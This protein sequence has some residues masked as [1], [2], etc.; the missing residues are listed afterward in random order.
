M[1]WNSTTTVFHPSAGSKTTR[2]TGLKIIRKQV[3]VLRACI[4]V[5]TWAFRHTSVCWRWQQLHRGRRAPPIISSQ[6]KNA[7]RCTYSILREAKMPK[8]AV[9]KLCYK[10]KS[11]FYTN[12]ATRMTLLAVL[13]EPHVSCWSNHSTRGAQHR[14]LTPAC[15]G[16]REGTSPLSRKLDILVEVLALFHVHCHCFAFVQ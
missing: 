14:A 3:R 5:C 12:T 10:Q 1:K 9:I 16:C 4:C 6:H 2:W 7:R 8:K 11:A 15:W 13:Q